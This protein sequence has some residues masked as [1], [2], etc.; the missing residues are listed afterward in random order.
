MVKILFYPSIQNYAVISLTTSVGARMT[1]IVG[2]RLHVCVPT[3]KGQNDK[4]V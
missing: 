3:F 4:L 2:N 1:L